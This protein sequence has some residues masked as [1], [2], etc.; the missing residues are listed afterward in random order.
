M[1]LPGDD[2]LNELFDTAERSRIANRVIWPAIEAS[3]HGPDWAF[4]QLLEVR[5]WFEQ[6]EPLLP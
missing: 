2:V 1:R 4:E 6:M 3:L 5:R